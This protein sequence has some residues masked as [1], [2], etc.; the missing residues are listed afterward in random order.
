MQSMRPDLKVLFNGLETARIN[1][2][3]SREDVEKTLVLG[4]GWIELFESGEREPSLGAL[5]ALLSLYDI[6]LSDFFKDLELSSEGVIPDR[7]LSV[8]AVDDGLNLHFPMGAYNARVRFEKATLDEYNE[9]LLIMRNRLAAGQ[10]KE[11]IV[12][13]FVKAVELWPHLNPSDLW[14]FFMSHAYQDDYNHPAT[15]AGRDWSQSWK[16]AGGWS[17]EA[18]YVKHYN[19]FLAQHG[20]EL[21]MPEPATK[22]GLLAQMGIVGQ[23]GVEKSDVIATGLNA[24]GEMQ[25]F[26]VIHV[27][28]SF[29][30]RRTD[31]VPLSKQLIQSNYASPLLTMD[32][33]ASPREL[34]FNKGELGPVQGGTGKVSSKRIDIERDRTFDAAFSYN[35]NTLATP[36]NSNAAA[37]I[38]VCNFADP[39]DLFSSYLIRKWNDRQ[40][41]H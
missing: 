18:V 10:K 22:V 19:P 2:G 1:K 33:K 32:C 16:R 8:E 6:N 15:S 3:L 5:A 4:P 24:K 34:P 41:I 37:R 30:E 17:L 31:D 36:P 9:V 11:A 29:A 13:A 39:D 21:V 26:G 38:Y 35:S 40:G 14:Y 20:I 7:H 25:P 28:A 23:A 27:K 12:D